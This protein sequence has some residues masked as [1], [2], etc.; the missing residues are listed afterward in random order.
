[1]F[2][3]NY[4]VQIREDL[5]LHPR[6]WDTANAEIKNPPEG[7]GG[8]YG[9]RLYICLSLIDPQPMQLIVLQSKRLPFVSYFCHS[10]PKP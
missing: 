2:I 10:T 9:I 5:P 6:Q 7:G 3:Y 1:M 8:V 4:I